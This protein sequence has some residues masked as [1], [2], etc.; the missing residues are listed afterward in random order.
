M[1]EAVPL[2]PGRPLEH[3][4]IPTVLRAIL[5]RLEKGDRLDDLMEE[6]KR[7]GPTQ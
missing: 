5:E 4:D 1:N 2:I 3:R 6:M 7:D